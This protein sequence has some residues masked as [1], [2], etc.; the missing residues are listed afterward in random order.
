M[1]EFLPFKGVLYNPKLIDD[2]SN[3]VTPPYDVISPK[4]QEAYYQKS[5]YN[6]VRLILGKSEPGDSSHS[7]IHRRLRGRTCNSDR[8]ERGNHVRRP[9]PDRQRAF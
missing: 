4:E 2:M 1:A 8:T 7:D 6:I 3:V 9:G 5:P